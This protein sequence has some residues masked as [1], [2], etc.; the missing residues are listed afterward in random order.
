M[1]WAL[2]AGVCFS[3]RSPLSRGR[4]GKYLWRIIFVVLFWFWFKSKIRAG[5][6]NLHNGA[7]ITAAVLP[8]I[9]ADCS[10]LASGGTWRLHSHT[11][12]GVE[13]NITHK[14]KMSYSV[15]FRLWFHPQCSEVSWPIFL[16]LLFAKFLTVA[17]LLA[18]TDAGLRHQLGCFQHHRGHER[19]QVYVQSECSV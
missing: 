5:R 14:L 3:L 17:A 1:A 18:V 8:G 9:N 12:S 10:K 6:G 19:V 15:I 7:Y 2:G 4:G 13:W 16:S 11:A